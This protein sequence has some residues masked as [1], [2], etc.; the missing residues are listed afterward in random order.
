[1]AINNKYSNIIIPSIGAGIGILVSLPFGSVLTGIYGAGFISSSILKSSSIFIGMGAGY[2]SNK[3]NSNKEKISDIIRNFDYEKNI[4]EEFKNKDIEIKNKIKNQ[5]DISNDLFKVLDNTEHPL[6]NLYSKLLCNFYDKNIDENDNI[7]NE[8]K[9]LINIIYYIY[10]NI[11]IND[12]KEFLSDNNNVY[13]LK[14]IINKSEILVDISD[15][16]IV[17]EDRKCF[18]SRIILERIILNN[19]YPFIFRNIKTK[20][21]EQNLIY[22]NNIN[23]LKEYNIDENPLLLDMKDT[24]TDLNVFKKDL[25]NINSIYPYYDKNI[26]LLNIYKKINNL[27]YLKYNKPCTVEDLVPLICY[28]VI[29]CDIPC[30]YL[31]IMYMNDFNTNIVSE[32][33]IHSY[34]FSTFYSVVDLIYKFKEYTN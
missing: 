16:D 28:I 19:L 18:I 29:Y 5:Y 20:Y 26:V 12:P 22:I 9:M 7:T 6:G 2:Y 33:G 21:T 8:S 17:I 3:N 32:C 14:E 23:L 34:V 10:L 24:L 13:E 4:I 25:L 31:E 27:Y 1:M 30:F 11:Y 15:L